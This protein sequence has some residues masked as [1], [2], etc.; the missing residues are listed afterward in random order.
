MFNS[1]V[2]SKSNFVSHRI[3]GDKI[4]HTLLVSPSSEAKE[5][6][7]KKALRIRKQKKPSPQYYRG[8]ISED[9]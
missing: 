7:E 3:H 9:A 8:S 4:E 6:E 5:E 2:F 1:H